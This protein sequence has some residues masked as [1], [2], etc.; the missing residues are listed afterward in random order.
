MDVS[1]DDAYSEYNNM[2]IGAVIVA[3]L[4]IIGI[5]LLIIYL[6]N[7][8]NNNNN[9][10]NNSGNNSSN[11]SG[12]NSDCSVPPNDKPTITFDSVFP[13]L[14]PQNGAPI[15][16]PSMHTQ[17]VDQ[18]I[19]PQTNKPD[20]SL[21][22]NIDDNGIL[23]PMNSQELASMDSNLGIS[24][25]KNSTDSDSSSED[26][27]PNSSGPKKISDKKSKGTEKKPRDNLYK[28]V[29]NSISNSNS[30]TSIKTE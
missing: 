6:V 22:G 15:G 24:P 9:S 20:N 14:N 28:V 16:V 21:N 29:N 25:D 2:N 30:G 5:V 26:N 23:S 11:N 8:N 27:T 12:N 7:N 19:L 13:K 4:L 18:N 17:Q 3:I 1:T 10:G